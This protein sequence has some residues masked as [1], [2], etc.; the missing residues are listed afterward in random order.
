VSAHEDRAAATPISKVQL[1][2]V[3]DIMLDGKPGEVVAKGGDP[4]IEF[5]SIL[6]QADFAIGNLECVISQTG[7][8]VSKRFTFR[9]HPRVIPLL[10]R[11]FDAV[12][13]ANNHTGDFGPAAFVDQLGRLDRGTVRHFGGG[14]NL[15]EAHAPLIIERNGL[16]IALLGYDEFKP[17]SFEA[18]RDSPGVA[19]S[20]DEE[21]QVVADIKSARSAHG[22]DLVIP[23]MHWGSEDDTEPNER[24]GI[25]ARTMIDAGADVVVGA[26]PHIVQGTEYYNGRLIVYSL[27]NF[28]FDGYDGRTGWVLRLTLT[29]NG[30]LEWDTVVART[31][32]QGVPHRSCE[33]LSPRGRSGS[34]AIVMGN[35]VH[36]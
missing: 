28:V 25:L 34:E 3:G 18:G 29:K 31:D 19:W 11:Y 22:A 26:H 33:A 10:S 30:L 21:A 5:G 15:E 12:S 32:E 9:A 16:R 8:R 1:V 36:P 13:L 4:F 24:Q 6:R 14:R 23:F 20:L 35:A 7:E 17:R 2:L 27:G